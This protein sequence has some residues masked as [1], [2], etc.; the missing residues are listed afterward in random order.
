MH[1]GSLGSGRQ[2]VMTCAEGAEGAE[3]GA[4]AEMVMD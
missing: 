2:D 1:C 4:G 3:G